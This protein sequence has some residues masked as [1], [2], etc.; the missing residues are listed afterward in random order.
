MK[1]M[2]KI[3]AVFVVKDKKLTQIG[4]QNPNAPSSIYIDDGQKHEIK[5]IAHDLSHI[6]VYYTNGQVL[7]SGGNNCG[8]LGL[9]R[10]SYIKDRERV[11]NLYLLMTNSDIKSIH[12]N[13]AYSMIIM[14]NGDLYVFGCNM[15]GQLGI[16]SSKLV[17]APTLSMN[18]VDQVACGLRHSL[19]LKKNGD[20]YVAGDNNY[21][22]LGNKNHHNSEPVFLMK[23]NVNQIMCGKNF[24]MILLDNGQILGFGSN[25]YGQLGFRGVE[26]QV[27]PVC[28]PIDNIIQIACAVDY[29]VVLNRN[30]ELFGF[31]SNHF[32]Q[33]GLG[34]YRD[35]YEPTFI[36][37]N[38][39]ICQ[40]L[41]QE[42]NTFVREND[43]NLFMCGKN[44]SNVLVLKDTNI[45]LLPNCRSLYSKT[46][47][48]ESH[49]LYP[50]NFNK[51]VTVF[52]LAIHVKKIKN[53]MPKYI[54]YMI[55]NFFAKIY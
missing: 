21:G 47:S 39:N 41:C 53:I 19:F 29:S 25:C 8:Q 3:N 35:R 48:I 22:Q 55:I 16:T 24:S 23:Q 38:N 12:C 17:F 10:F 51:C 20:I 46:W 40:I 1:K 28:L 11:G 7:V 42:D 5:Q 44:I 52:L 18:Q 32:G 34:D 49:K 45:D 31:G 14:N 43:G 4:S 36:I 50:D 54:K 13:F 26:T 33:L 37:K 2:K 6:I 30:R 9:G 27:V 15:Y